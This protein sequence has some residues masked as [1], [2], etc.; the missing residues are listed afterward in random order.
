[1]KHS[2]YIDCRITFCTF[3]EDRQA[4]IYGEETYA[5]PTLFC[6]ERGSFDYAVGNGSTHTVGRG[7]AV[8]CPAGVPFRRTMRETASFCMIRLVPSVPVNLGDAPIT[9]REASRFLYD[10]DTLR[11][12]L[13]CRD[14]SN[15]PAYEH[16][17]R[18]IWFL[19]HPDRTGQPD[20]IDRALETIRNRYHTPLTVRSLADEAGYSTVHFINRFKARFGLTPGAEITRLR[21]ERA[22]ELLKNTRLPIREVAAASGYDDEFYFS[23]LFHRRFQI[24]PRAFR[25]LVDGGEGGEEDVT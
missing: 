18:D 1:M 16:F 9:P 13:F 6:V 22:R 4:F 21:L 24:S 17:C 3:F 12:C 19:L 5:E 20:A 8:F 2:D 14:F 10:L 7:Q 15:A 23:R 11:G 25:G